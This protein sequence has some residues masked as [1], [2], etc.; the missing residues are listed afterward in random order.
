MDPFFPLLAKLISSFSISA[1]LRLSQFL[2]T[3]TNNPVGV[4]TA[5]EISQ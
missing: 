1:K 4:A 5:T 2:K 3:G